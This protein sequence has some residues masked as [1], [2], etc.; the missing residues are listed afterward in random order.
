MRALRDRMTRLERRI[1]PR[2][3]VDVPYLLT[4]LDGRIYRDEQGREYVYRD[5]CFHRTDAEGRAPI[6]TKGQKLYW[7]IDLARMV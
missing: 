5:Q 1:E 4:T 2:S 7:G 3:L 6:R